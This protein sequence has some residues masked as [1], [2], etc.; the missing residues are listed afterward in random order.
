MRSVLSVLAIG[1]V[2]LSLGSASRGAEGPEGAATTQPTSSATQPASVPAEKLAEI[3]KLFEPANVETRA[4]WLRLVTGRMEKA[5]RLGAEAKQSYPGAANL[6]KVRMLML[7]AAHVLLQV[8]GTPLSARRVTEIAAEVITSGAPA[9]DRVVADWLIVAEKVKPAGDEQ[10][11]KEP[12]KE[13][14][15]L[16]KRYQKTDAAAD[17]VTYA[18]ILAAQTRQLALVEE[19]ADVLENKHLDAPDVR[20]ILRQIGRHPDVGKPFRAELTTLA[21]KKLSLP[22]ALRG[23]VVVIDFWAT[24]CP[25]CVASLPHM[26]NLYAA[27]KDKGVEFVGVSLDGDK[28]TLEKFVKDNKLEWVQTYADKGPN[29]P[30]AERYGIFGIPSIW[31]IGRDGNVISDNAHV[32][33][34]ATIEKALKTEA[35]E[36]GE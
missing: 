9:K 33:L 35:K 3:E 32:D 10:A 6:G 8:R 1:A 34:E 11:V 19:L 16:A 28:K 18:V 23:K 29:D 5:L 26:K 30:T 14:R 20:S 17:A 13:I 7:Q 4:L 27:Y 2:I 36:K 12:D 25:P 22:E 31:V 21:G 24:S 15:A